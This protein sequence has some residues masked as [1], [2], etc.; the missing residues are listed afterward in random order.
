[1]HQRYEMPRRLCYLKHMYSLMLDRQNS[2][3]PI[4]QIDP[5]ADVNTVEIEVDLITDFAF[6]KNISIISKGPPLDRWNKTDNRPS[7]QC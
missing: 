7:I 2:K 3:D 4:N 5:L 6:L 1:M